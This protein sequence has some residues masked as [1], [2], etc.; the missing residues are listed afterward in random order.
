MKMPVSEMTSRR[1]D[2]FNR[3][4]SQ[5][6]RIIALLCSQSNESSV[7]EARL[8]A[9][10]TRLS[11]CRAARTEAQEK[12]QPCQE[13]AEAVAD[14]AEDSVGGIA[15]A[16]LEATTAEMA[17]RLHVTNDGLDG[18]APTHLVSDGSEEAT[19]LS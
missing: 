13:E 2:Q 8:S 11:L 9:N 19:L 18:G 17:F 12:P 16:S 5:L 4:S 6:L 7:K 15:V 10:W 3:T 1:H 14:G